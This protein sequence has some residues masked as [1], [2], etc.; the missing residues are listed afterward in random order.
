MRTW[1]KFEGSIS[2]LAKIFLQMNRKFNVGYNYCMKPCQ[3]VTCHSHVCLSQASV[4]MKGLNVGSCKQCHTIAQGLQFSDAADLG[5]TQ[6]GWPPTEASNAEGRL[7]LTTFDKSLAITR[8]CRPSQALLT[9]FSHKF[10]TLSVHLCLH[11]VC[12]DAVHCTG[13]SAIDDA[14][15]DGYCPLKGRQSCVL[16]NL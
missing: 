8:K 12:R 6:M 13:L 5:K 3:H 1:R 15:F 14:Y 10:I 16:D 11:Q 7:K 4:L 2:M 9:Q